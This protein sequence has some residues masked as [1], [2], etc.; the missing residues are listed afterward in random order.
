VNSLFDNL[1]RGT[2]YSKRYKTWPEIDGF[3]TTW[4]ERI[5]LIR[6]RGT[7]SEFSLSDHKPKMMKIANNSSKM[8]NQHPRKEGKG[9][10]L[11][12]L[13]CEEV[14][15]NFQNEMNRK[16]ICREKLGNGITWECLAKMI[17]E[18]GQQVV[19]FKKKESLNRCF[20]WHEEEIAQYKKGIMEYSRKIARVGNANEKERLIYKRRKLRKKFK[21][22][23][24]QWENEWWERKMDECKAAEQK[25]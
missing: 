7:D 21:E 19:G 18:T 13:D 6:N 22:S 15:M 24:N 25:F 20:N 16:L 5:K 12:K 17:Q 3:V 2:W 8:E 1:N 9:I 10:D 23:K 14:R 4:E 11:E